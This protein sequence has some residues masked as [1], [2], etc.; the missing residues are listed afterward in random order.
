MTERGRDAVVIKRTE[1]GALLKF[2]DG[3]ERWTKGP[4]RAP[5]GTR[6]R[7]YGFRVPPP[8]DEE[9]SDSMV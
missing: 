9:P 8:A 7:V 4:T 2:E 3:E 1:D 6:C 5:V